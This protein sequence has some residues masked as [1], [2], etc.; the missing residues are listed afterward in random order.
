M[1][2]L[3][4]AAL[5]AVSFA[6]YTH[7]T[8]TVTLYADKIYC[9][10]CVAVIT[11]ALRSVAGVGNVSVDVER[12]EIRVQFDP[13]RASLEDLTAAT[14]KKGFPATVKASR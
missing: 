7:E 11:K 5:L 2:R 12:K 8:K 13:G 10:A 1:K 3:A 14:A 9:G 6:A 4:L